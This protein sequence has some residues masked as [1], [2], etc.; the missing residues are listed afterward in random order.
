LQGLTTLA[1]HLL[2]YWSMRP[3]VLAVT[4]QRLDR[5]VNHAFN[6]PAC[7]LLFH[8]FKPNAKLPLANEPGVK[9][10]LGVTLAEVYSALGLYQKSDALVRR[11]L[12]IAHDDR[13][14]RARQLAALGESQYRLGEYEASLATFRRAAA[15]SEGSSA[16]LRSL[17]L[18]GMGEALTAL[19]RTSESHR[20]LRQALH[21]D[22]RRGEA[23]GNDVAHDLEAIGHNYLADGKLDLARPFF[24]RALP[25]RRQF[26]G[27]MSPSLSDIYNGLG[28]IAYARHELP[29]AERYFRGNLAVD[30][31]VLGPEHPDVAT[32]MN[33]L[34]RALIEQRRHDEA[35]PLLQ[36]ALS[37]ARKERGDGH[38]DMAFVFANLAIASRHTGQRR[39]AET[40]F[41]QSIAAARQNEHRILGPSLADLAEIRCSVGRAK[42]AMALLD[43]AAR[44][45]AADYPDKPWRQAWVENI[46]GECM[47]RQGRRSDGAKRI[48]DSSKVI[49]REWPRGTLFANEA[50][51][52]LRWSRR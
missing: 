9:A 29:A 25:L 31:K 10:E 19:G 40:L 33:N 11:T 46:R 18:V 32:T 4:T 13:T 3:E 23:A 45:T 50:E 36:Q 16:A 51:R 35:R 42:E 26:E 14:T 47:I 24:L 41:E 22:Q 27:P 44:A 5:L 37:I 39:E 48:A 20:V 6:R 49:L 38:P 30:R 12:S 34:A 2:E 7:A 43:E 15:Q 28:S 1:L 8:P 52:R 17:I 21:I